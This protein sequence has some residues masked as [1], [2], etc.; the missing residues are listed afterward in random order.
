MPTDRPNIVIIVAHPD[1]VSN[2]MGGTALLL[3]DKYALHVLCATRGERGIRGKSYDEAGA[4][5]EKEEA[6]A[7]KLLDASLTFLDR[8]NGQLFADREICQR[9]ADLLKDLRPVAV[10]TLWPLNRHEDHTTVYEITIKALGL[11]G[12]KDSVQLYMTENSIGGQTIQFDPD[13]YVDITPV[14]DAKRAV[15][16]CHVSQNQGDLE[17][18]IKRNRIRGLF[19]NCDYAEAFKTWYPLVTRP[20]APTPSILLE[21]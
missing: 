9:V 5:R 17:R 20:N 3:K 1:D 13:L 16:A 18:V 6:A 15:V 14:I 8:I 12:L 10:F 11:A 19:A 7:C 2:S 4:I 21:L